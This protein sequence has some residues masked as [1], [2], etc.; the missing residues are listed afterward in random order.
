MQ[1]MR[2]Y[3]TLYILRPDLTDESI[4]QVNDKMKEI[5]NREGAKVLSCN[6]WGK[7]KLAF[8][9][10]K[11]PKGFFFQMCYLSGPTVIREFERNLKL[12]EPVIRYQTIKVAD[13]VNVEKRIAEAE[14]ENRA[15]EAAEAEARERAER[16]R[17]EREEAEAQARAAA[18]AENAQA[19]AEAA[20]ASEPENPAEA[21]KTTEQEEE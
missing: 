16:E 12:S 1:T 10:R 14:A 3:E 20:E 2:E 21:S 6:A 17:I 15:R 8:E 7:K 4:A 5:L 11:Q 9:V 13:T 18:E 19:E